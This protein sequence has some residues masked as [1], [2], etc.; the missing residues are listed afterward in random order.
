MAKA[1][2]SLS[3]TNQC[4]P[5]NSPHLTPLPYSYNNMGIGYLL[6]IFLLLLG[7]PDGILA[8]LVSSPVSTS[9]IIAISSLL[10]SSLSP[11]SPFL[12]AEF[13][14]PSS[15]SPPRSTTVSSVTTASEGNQCQAGDLTGRR[16]FH[17]EARWA[18]VHTWKLRL[19]GLPAADTGGS[20]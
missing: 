10:S 11:A 16:C 12:A 15:T 6:F 7:A 5:F 19:I 8:A 9:T 20:G 18:M 17:P 14:S 1:P 2:L 13:Y 4:R 3:H